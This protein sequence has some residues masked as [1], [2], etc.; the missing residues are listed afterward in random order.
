MFLVQLCLSN[1]TQQGYREW[2][3]ELKFRTE[4]GRANSHTCYFTSWGQLSWMRHKENVMVEPYATVLA[5]FLNSHG[6]ARLLACREL[7]PSVE[8]GG[9]ALIP[10][11]RHPRRKG[12]CGHTHINR[13]RETLWS[14]REEGHC[15]GQERGL[16]RVPSTGVR[17]CHTCRRLDPLLVAS[18]TVTLCFYRSR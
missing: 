6:R 4:R 11:D 2:S 8:G 1:I 18:R 12:K 5:P 15:R 7:G 9:R 3:D 16:K 14:P 17:R 13:K 10:P